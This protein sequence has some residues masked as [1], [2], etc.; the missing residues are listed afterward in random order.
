[1]AQATTKISSKTENKANLAVNYLK[2]TRDI[3]HTQNP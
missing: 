2:K 3:S 1:M